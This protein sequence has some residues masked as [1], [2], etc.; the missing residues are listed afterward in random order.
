M[1]YELGMAW[2]KAV[3]T[4]FK[5]SPQQLLTARDKNQDNSQM[6]ELVTES[7]TQEYEA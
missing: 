7:R 6:V 3:V 2:K 5:L 1:N 4:C